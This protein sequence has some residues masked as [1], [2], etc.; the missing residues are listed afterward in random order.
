LRSPR[1]LVVTIVGLIVV[2]I[3]VAVL[4][5]HGAHKPANNNPAFGSSASS[6]PGSGVDMGTSSQ[7]PS[8]TT[9]PQTRL[10]APPTPQTAAPDPSALAVIKAWAQAWV[11]HPVGMTNQQW[12][13]QLQPFTTP[14]FLQDEMSSVDVANIP[15]TAVTGLPVVVHS[16]TDS[17]EATIATNGGI[18]DITAVNTGSNWQVNAY[19]PVGG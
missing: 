2:V 18:L 19:N 11:D 8:G 16:Y 14:E 12:L 6:T 17:V 9:V 15:A 5:N 4:V 3:A 13:A 10:S 7:S 1:H